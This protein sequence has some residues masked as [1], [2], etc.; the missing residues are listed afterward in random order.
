MKFALGLTRRTLA[1]HV[2]CSLTAWC[3][4]PGQTLDSVIAHF[5]T[6]PDVEM[7]VVLFTIEHKLRF[8]FDCLLS[9]LTL[10]FWCG[11]SSK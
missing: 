9:W 1:C 7:L 8:V 6:G 3:C 11:C 4:L 2:P 5:A 10:V